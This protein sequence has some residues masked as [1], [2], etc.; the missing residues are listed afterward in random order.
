MKNTIFKMSI[1]TMALIKYLTE[2]KDENGLITYQEL[3][4]VIG[5]DIQKEA[6]GCL[7]TAQNRLL[8]DEGISFGVIRGEGIRKLSQE[9]V[10][11]AS[12][13]PIMRSRRLAK[14]GFARLTKGIQD[15]ENLPREKQIKHNVA[16][17]IFG[18]INHMTKA[19]SIQKLIPAVEKA[20]GI[21]PVMKTIEA[22]K[23][24]KSD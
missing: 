22:F 15:F 2:K 18:M 13:A 8:N 20:S 17:S 10:V 6:R 14:R 11:D 3:S 12:D 1:D 24:E 16:A 21:L 9:E 19:K 7:K 5:R 4:E 23:K